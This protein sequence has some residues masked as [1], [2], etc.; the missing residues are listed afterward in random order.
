MT[1]KTDFTAEE[2]KGVLSGPPAAGLMV[3]IAQRGGSFRESYSIA[4]AYA[5]ARKH[6]G[7]SELLDAIVAEKPELERPHGGSL[8]DVKAQTLQRMREASQLVEQKATPEE[9]EDYKR[10]VLNLAQKVAEAHRE[11][12]LGVS[13]ERVSEAEQN[14]VDEIAQ[15]LGIESR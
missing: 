1:G 12:F 14:A 7:E 8:E 2:W 15:A 6:H 10:F 13:G 9:A 4:N 5:E 11:G 3:A